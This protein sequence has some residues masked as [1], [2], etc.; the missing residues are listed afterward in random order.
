MKTRNIEIRDALRENSVY[1]YEVAEALNISEAKF[2]K[3]LRKELTKK[4]KTIVL[5]TI[6]KVALKNMTEEV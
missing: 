6:R 3:M 4:E 5:D 1:Q 2:S